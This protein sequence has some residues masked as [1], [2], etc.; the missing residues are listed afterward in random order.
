LR[1]PEIVSAGAV[2]MALLDVG[3]DGRPEF[4]HARLPFIQCNFVE[5]QLADGRFAFFQNYQND[6]IFG[7]MIDLRSVGSIEAHWSESERGE[8]PSTY[9]A[10][11]DFISVVGSIGH[12]EVGWMEATFRKLN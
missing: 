7:L 9:R 11:P 6:D 2:E 10:A 3:L 5:L 8:E 1:E 12:V 4:R